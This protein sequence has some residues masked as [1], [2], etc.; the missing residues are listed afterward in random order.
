MAKAD[1]YRCFFGIIKRF[2]DHNGNPQVY[3]K[4][5][6]PNDGYIVAQERDQKTLGLNL[7]EICIMRLDMGLHYY[8]G[9][10]KEISG[11]RYFIN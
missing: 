2:E 5:V 7:D 6:M 8:V 9:L 3:S 11:I 10:Y 4:I 1:R